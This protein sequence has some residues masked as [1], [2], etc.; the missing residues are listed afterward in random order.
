[1]N[2]ILSLLGK[3]KEI[4]AIVIL[5]GYAVNFFSKNFFND[6]FVKTGIWLILTWLNIIFFFYD[7]I[8]KCQQNNIVFCMHKVLY[9]CAQFYSSTWY[10]LRIHN[11][12]H[13]QKNIHYGLI[14]VHFVLMDTFRI[15]QSITSVIDTWLYHWSIF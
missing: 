15:L 8:H 5:T 10:K 2:W 1:M 14:K 12:I 13:Q 7:L 11:F 4:N 3:Y 9:T 6:F